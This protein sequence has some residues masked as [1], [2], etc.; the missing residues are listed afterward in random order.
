MV[1]KYHDGG[2]GSQLSA[3]VGPIAN[4][5]SHARQIKASTI[6]T[7]MASDVIAGVISDH[8][9]SSAVDTYLI[10]DFSE[11]NSWRV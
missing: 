10:Y 7:E 1:E 3:A 9:P 2:L 6:I 8:I 11:P 4:D 5:E